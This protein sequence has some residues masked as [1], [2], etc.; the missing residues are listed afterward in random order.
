MGAG[1]LGRMNEDR[2]CKKIFLTKPMG[3]RPRSRPPFRW[4]ECVERD[5]KIVKIKNWKTVAKS[6]YAWRRQGR[7]QGCRAIEEED[8]N[9]DSL[10]MILQK[11]YNF[12][13]IL[14]KNIFNI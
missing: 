9:Y 12:S 8:I 14:M 10:K 13:L 6:R 4:V 2:C 3:K 7:T 1:H 5:L 11:Q